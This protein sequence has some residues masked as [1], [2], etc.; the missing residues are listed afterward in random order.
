MKWLAARKEMSTAVAE[1]HSALTK[2]RNEEDFRLIMEVMANLP[3]QALEELKGPVNTPVSR[4]LAEMRAAV[5]DLGN[6]MVLRKSEPPQ[7]R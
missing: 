7:G 2:C 6:A 4:R 5:A 3:N 1:L